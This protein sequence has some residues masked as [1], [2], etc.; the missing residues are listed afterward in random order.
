VTIELAQR[1]DGVSDILRLFA[2]L[3][4]LEVVTI[5]ELEI[6]DGQLVDGEIPDG[7]AGPESVG[8]ILRQHPLVLGLALVGT[9]ATQV[10]ISAGE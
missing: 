5:G 4:V 8:E 9:V 1:P 3:A 2:W 6:L 10:V 7:G